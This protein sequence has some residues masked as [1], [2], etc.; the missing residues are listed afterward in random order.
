VESSWPVSNDERFRLVVLAGFAMTGLGLLTFGVYGVIAYTVSQ[1]TREFAIRL[2]LGGERRHVASQVF[3]T[4]FWL[5]GTGAL[6][7]LVVCLATGRVLASQLYETSPRDPITLA[8]A[9]GVIVLTGAIACAVPARRAMRVE[10]AVALRH[11][12]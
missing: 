5:V 7:G 2:A 10:P 9:L 6:I 11:D 12:E 3:R 4:T 8:A 1:Q